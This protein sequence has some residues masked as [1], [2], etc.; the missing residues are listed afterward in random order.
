MEKQ[1]FCNN[2]VL[3]YLFNKE[4]LFERQNRAQIIIFSLYSRSI[5]RHLLEMRNVLSFSKWT[6]IVLCCAFLPFSK[7]VERVWRPLLNVTFNIACINKL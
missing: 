3:A 4:Y 6:H 2:K 5:W 1:Y 7:F